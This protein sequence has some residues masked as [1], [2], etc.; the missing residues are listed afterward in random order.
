[1]VGLVRASSSVGFTSARGE[2]MKNSVE[3]T[4]EI[5]T[6]TS[7]FRPAAL[8]R[9]KSLVPRAKPAPMIGPMSGEMSMAPIIT[10]VEFTLRPTEAITMEKARIHTLVPRNQI[11]LLMRWAAPAVSKSS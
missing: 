2:T 1:M 3:A 4:S 8:S 7:R 11:L 5:S 10:A 9:S 6:I